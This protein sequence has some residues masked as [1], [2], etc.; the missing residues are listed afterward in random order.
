MKVST[1]VSVRLFSG[2]RYAASCFKLYLVLEV[3]LQLDERCGGPSGHA[4]AASAVWLLVQRGGVISEKGKVATHMWF[5]R[6]G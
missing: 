2:Y 1:I 6:D 3:A 4:A 5:G